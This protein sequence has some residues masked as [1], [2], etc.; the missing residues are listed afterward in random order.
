ML[1]QQQHNDV[2]NANQYRREQAHRLL[3]RAQQCLLGNI[4]VI[5]EMVQYGIVEETLMQHED[6]WIWK[7][8][9]Q[10]GGLIQGLLVKEGQKRVK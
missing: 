5:H 6:Q 4:L 3:E 9:H 7:V 2:L 1:L 8:F 10:G